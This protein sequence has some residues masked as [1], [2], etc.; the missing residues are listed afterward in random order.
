MKIT[1]TASGKYN[2]H[3]RLGS[4]TKSITAKTPQAVERKARQLLMEYDR[5]I[6]TG[7]TVGEAIDQYIESKKSVLSV[8]TVALY[9]NIRDKNCQ[10][11]MG[12][13]VSRLTN[14]DIQKEISREAETH[15]PKTVANMR[16]LLSAALRQHGF[17]VDVSVPQNPKKILELPA[18]ED[19]IR[20]IR[21]KDIELPA[22]LAIW[23]S[24]SM[25]EIRGIQVSSIRDGYLIIQ[26]STVDVGGET[27]HKTTTKAYER[28]RKLRLPKHIM[29]LIEQTDAWKAG[30]GYIVPM[31]RRTIY[32]HFTKAVSDA[33]LPHLTFHQLRH[34]NAS[35]M[36]MLG[37]GERYAME[38]GGWA[39]RSVL[40]NVYQ[41][42][43]SSERERVDDKI[44]EYFETFLK[45]TISK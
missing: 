28:T 14:Q 9:Q 4:S 34:L 42:T 37:I 20:A 10:L 38:R 36:L 5:K 23:L 35:V 19:V 3:I 11:I 25:S 27:I 15:K 32:S 39:T 43:F 26:E 18:A 31:N 29:G 30:E 45:Q 12:I 2:A 24:C 40:Q 16:G 17:D 8:T 6:Q 1:E 41:H 44:D 13:P 33:G 7:V 22:M 21:G